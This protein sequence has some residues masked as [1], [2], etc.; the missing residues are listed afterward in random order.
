MKVLVTHLYTNATQD[1]IRELFEQYGKVDEVE[2]FFSSN[3]GQRISLC[4][5]EMPNKNEG[6]A[7]IK[8]LHGT[9]L[10]EQTLN[11]YSL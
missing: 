7:A 5:V 11:V 9:S 2:F 8:G 4:L 1:E 3:D 10:G 6:E